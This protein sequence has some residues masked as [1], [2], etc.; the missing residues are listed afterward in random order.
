MS[1]DVCF[2]PISAWRTSKAVPQRG[3]HH[4]EPSLGDQ[5][6][7]MR[8]PR[9]QPQA[10]QREIRMVS[11]LVPNASF[12]SWL[13]GDDVNKTGESVAFLM[14]KI[15][16]TGFFR[17]YAVWRQGQAPN[18]C[19][20]AKGRFISVDGPTGSCSCPVTS[21][22]QGVMVWCGTGRYQPAVHPLPTPFR[23]LS[24]GCS[25]SVQGI[26]QCGWLQTL[27]Q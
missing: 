3:R 15:R 9:K 13:R 4:P 5:G 10:G 19:L 8:F 11:L 6:R 24:Q 26:P 2:S 12:P 14:Q 27:L 22:V 18:L 17:I 20:D 7:K 21:L 16:E 25:Q 1:S 23:Q